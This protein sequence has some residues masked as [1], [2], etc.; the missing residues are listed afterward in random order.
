MARRQLLTDEER[1]ALFGFPIDLDGPTRCFTLSRSG[2]KLVAER[3]N[4]TSRLGCAVQLALLRHPGTT[5]ANLNQRV[6]PLV[7]WMA[8]QLDIPAGAFARYSQRPQTVTDHARKL[9]PAL[10]VRLATA[11][12][13]PLIV[14][15]AA[16]AARG[17]DAGAPIAAGV[18]VALRRARI[19]PPAVAVI[20]RTAIAGR[21][22][23]PQRAEETLSRVS[24]RRRR[25][26]SGW[27]NFAR[28]R[29][30]AD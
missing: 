28:R 5:L 30:A 23:A 17:T 10:G 14:E 8:E 21:A 18:V 19:L 12:D 22:R 2:R 26:S 24:R 11:V 7:A 13:L 3:R 4:D 20:E 27:L 29:I 1:Q 15:A 6:E 9:A 25:T 16:E